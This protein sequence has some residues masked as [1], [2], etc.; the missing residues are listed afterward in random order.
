MTQSLITAKDAG[1]ANVNFETIYDNTANTHAPVH[2]CSGATIAVNSNITRPNANVAFTAN[3]AFGN[4]TTVIHTF[5]DVARANTGSGNIIS[6]KVSKG[7]VAGG[8]N[9]PAGFRARLWL[10]DDLP[11]TTIVDS[12]TFTFSFSERTKRIGYVDFTEWA[13]GSDCAESYATPF[14]APLGFTSSSNNKL[15]GV[16]QS[17]TAYPPANNEI[18][19]ITLTIIQD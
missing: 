3:A 11:S 6:A 14:I 16:L 1:Q 7:G 2:F 5:S 8:N 19:D 12:N 10:F 9:I 15:Y 17:L 18:F 13:V 4:S